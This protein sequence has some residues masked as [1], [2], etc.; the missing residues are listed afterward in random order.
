MKFAF[1]WLHNSVLAA[2][3]GSMNDIFLRNR[4]RK[5]RIEMLTRQKYDVRT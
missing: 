5:R 2:H 4:R 1:N 3:F